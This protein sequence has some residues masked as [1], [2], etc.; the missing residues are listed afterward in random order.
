MLRRFSQLIVLFLSMHALSAAENGSSDPQLASLLQPSRSPL[1]NFRLL[2]KTGAADDPEG[3]EGV[4]SLTAALLAKGG[5]RAFSYDQILEAF[6]PMATS[7]DAQ[8]DK[9]MTVFTGTTHADNLARYYA[10]IRD[11]LLAPGFREDDFTRLKTEAM[12]FLSVS[13]REGNDEELG[14]EELYNTIYQKRP[15]GHHDLGTLS[16]LEK[17]NLEDV[18]SF[19]REHYRRG[20]LVVGLAGGYPAAF[21]QQVEHDFQSLPPGHTSRPALPQPKLERGLKIEMVERET[22]STAISIGFPISVVRG[23]PDWPALAL[24]ES[25]FG[26]HR[27]SNSHLYQRLREARGLNYGDY[28]YIEYFPRGMFQFAPDPNLGRHQQ[29]FQIWI[30]P[31]EPQNGLFTLRAAFYEYDKLLRDGISQ[32][33]FETTRAFL[34]KYVNV[35]LQTQDARL[36]Y[37][38]DSQFYEIKSF[39]QYLHQALAQLTRDQV[40]DALRRRLKSDSI[41]VVIITKDGQALRD[42]LIKNAP[43]SITYNSPKSQDILDEDKTIERYALPLQPEAVTIRPVADLFVR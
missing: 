36:G 6:Y 42:A 2:F 35:L 32:D 38:L 43:S 14:K 3:K 41:R 20:N 24:I 8:V 5:S 16:A 31:V 11:M 13:L 23:D 19:Y 21:P 22:R 39:D 37:A 28:S 40:N 27:S 33:A 10:L 18:R 12:N 1:V 4:A 17:L 7:F 25:Y 30:R 9:E 15:Y 26:Q 34:D 29:I